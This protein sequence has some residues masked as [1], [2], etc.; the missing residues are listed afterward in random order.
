MPFSSRWPSRWSP[1]CCCAC[2]AT[3]RPAIA[4]EGARQEDI[5]LIRRT[6]GLDRPLPVQYLDWLW[7]TVRGDF[8]SSLYFKTDVI[9]PLI[10]GKLPT[11]LLLGIL[12][13]ALRAR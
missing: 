8:G 10:L 2:P 7:R 12:S 1:S 5:E 11:T 4:G 3:S 13:L 6:Y 9:G